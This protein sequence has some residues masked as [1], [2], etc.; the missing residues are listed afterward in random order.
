MSVRRRR[1]LALAIAIAAFVLLGGPLG[2]WLRESPRPDALAAGVPGRIVRVDGH[3]VHVVE[4]GVG[5]PLVLVHGFG[6]STFDYEEHVLARLAETHHVVAIDLYG[7]GWSERSPSFHYGWSL[8]A[9][10]IT[11]TLD[12]LGIAR[13]SLAG[14]S[15]GG[16][17]AAVWAARYPE[18]VDRLILADALYP[19]NDDEI[20][21]PFRVMA[22]PVLGELALALVPDATPPGASDAYRARARATYAIGGTRAGWLDYVRNPTR[23]SELAEAHPAITARTLVL[24]GT[25]DSF[26]PHAAMRRAAPH[27]AHVE[28][29][30]LDGGGH[31]PHRDD[32]DQYVARVD[33]FL[34]AP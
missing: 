9:E 28:I 10:Q 23:R 5:P 15:M 21:L 12:V 13:T 7:N 16:G 31:F 4:A 2:I 26:V 25:R 1:G 32:P 34:A 19:L 17:V 27:I 14:H 20:A 8:W 3:A 6:G 11:H 24:H 22:A 29:V 33:A 18:R 30:D